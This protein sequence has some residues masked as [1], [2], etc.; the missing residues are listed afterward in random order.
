MQVKQKL[1][2]LIGV[3]GVGKSTYA[4]QLLGER[5]FD[6]VPS[7]I[8]NKDS[9]RNMFFA[10]S[11]LG[12]EKLIDEMQMT[13]LKSIQG[14]NVILDNT[15]CRISTVTRL[16]EMFHKKY[17]IDLV[18]LGS[19]LAISEIIDRNNSRPIDKR[20]SSDS[21]NSMYQAFRHL[22]KHKDELDTLVE[23]RNKNTETTPTKKSYNSYYRNTNLPRAVIVDIDGT[24]AH[25]DGK[26]GPFDWGKVG[27]DSVDYNIAEL[28]VAIDQYYEI[29]Y[30][31]G[32]DEVCREQ[33]FSWLQTYVGLEVKH[34][35][36]R[37]AGSF[38]KDSVVKQRIYD[39]HIKDNYDVRFVL[40][41][42]NQV[43]EFWRSIGLKCLQVEEGNF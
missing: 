42:R 6:A 4:K 2:I 27:L 38:E 15:H 5:L 10:N 13:L 23:V 39:T 30:V 31:S 25:M 43:V 12:D 18:V 34:L 14:K 9:L 11:T 17:T 20:V 33:T 16:I 26:R 24:V 7:I 3:P 22:L 35:H 36:M 32:R 29:I 8:I 41:D 19:E 21:L 37:P 1:T 28:L 40:D